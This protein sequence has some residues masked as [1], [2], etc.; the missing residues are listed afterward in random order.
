MAT[1]CQ[2]S[3]MYLGKDNSKYISYLDK[4]KFMCGKCGRLANSDE[5]LCRPIPLQEEI[6]LTTN[7]ANFEKTNTQVEIKELNIEEENT[8]VKKL[9]VNQ[10]REI[11]REELKDIIGNL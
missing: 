1:M 3:K 8:K 9:K 6:N 10:F 7:I 4:P 5:N 11:I 2:L